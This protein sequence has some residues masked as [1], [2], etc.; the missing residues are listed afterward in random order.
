MHPTDPTTVKIRVYADGSWDLADE[1]NETG[2]DDYMLVNAPEDSSP[3]ELDRIA[4]KAQS[5]PSC[6]QFDDPTDPQPPVE[7]DDHFCAEL[8][9]GD[10]REYTGPGEPSPVALCSCCNDRIA[11][12]H[13]A[14]QSFCA[15]CYE[16][17]AARDDRDQT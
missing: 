1:P 17:G 2:C 9:L 10:A 8:D 5:I 11:T 6:L 3:E 13:E 16:A 4:E 15:T 12:I 14:S 7:D